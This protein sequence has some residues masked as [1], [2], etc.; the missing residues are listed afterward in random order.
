MYSDEQYVCNALDAGAKGY[1]LKNAID[2]DLVRAVKAVA[3]G[4]QDPSPELSGRADPRDQDRR[5]RQDGRS[6][7]TS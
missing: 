4:E 2:N 6:K 3:G 5:V 7:T 1:M